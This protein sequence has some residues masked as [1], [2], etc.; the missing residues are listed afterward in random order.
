MKNKNFIK[1]EFPNGKKLGIGFDP[2]D[3]NIVINMGN[4]E[5]VENKEEMEG[6]GNK[7]SMDNMPK[8][9][10]NKEKGMKL[11]MIRILC[12]LWE[13]GFFVD[14]N[15]RKAMK[16]EVFR[17]FGIMLNTDFSNHNSDLS[18]SLADGSSMNKH[19]R[20]FEMMLEKMKQIFN[21]A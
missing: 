11:D 18:G 13:L 21:Q 8:L 5:N 7:E 15:G 10:L 12:V 14:E 3:D 4:K 1:V 6:K 9:Y 17:G 2:T 19:L 16:K 20:I